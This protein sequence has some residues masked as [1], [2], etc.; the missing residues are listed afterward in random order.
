[1]MFYCIPSATFAVDSTEENEAAEIVPSS[2]E[3]INKEITFEKINDANVSEI[4]S[5]REESVK[6]FRLADGTYQAVAYGKPVHTLSADGT[7]EDIDNGL[8]LT[9]TGTVNT[10]ATKDNRISFAKAFTSNS[11]L[12]TLNE[13]GYT[14]SMALVTN[15]SSDHEIMS[16]SAVDIIQPI[17]T[18]IIPTVSNSPQRVNG[19]NTLD[20]AVLIDNDSSIKYNNVLPNTDIEYVINTG[21]V[22]EN[23]I[24][25]SRASSYSYVFRLELDGLTAEAYNNTV[26]LNDPLTQETI[27][28]I[29]MPYMY[30]ANGELSYNVTYE[31]AEI[32]SGTYALRVVAD[33][34]WINASQR[35]FPVTIDPTLNLI[36]EMDDTYC[37]QNYPNNNYGSGL[38][39]GVSPISMAFIKTAMPALPDGVTPGIS[40]LHLYY[41]SHETDSTTLVGAYKVLEN[42]NE[43]T[44]TWNNKPNID[45]QIQSNWRLYY[46]T[47]NATPTTPQKVW[48][49]ITEAVKDWY[50]NPSSNYGIA[51]K[52]ISGVSEMCFFRT[53]DWGSNL[54]RISISYTFQFEDGVY[55]IE[56]IGNGNYLSFNSST[57]A[58]QQ[59]SYSAQ[60]SISALDNTNRA[61]L[62]KLTHDNNTRYIV[63]LMYDNR[64]TF[65]V[66]DSGAIGMKVIPTADDDVASADTFYI[67][68]DGYGFVLR[69]YSGNYVINAGSGTT[70]STVNKDDAQSSARW[71][72]TKVNYSTTQTGGTVYMQQNIY[73]GH[74]TDYIPMLWSTAAGAETYMYIR[75]GTTDIITGTWNPTTQKFSLTPH[76]P[77]YF[78]V[79]IQI[80]LGDTLLFDGYIENP[81]VTLVVEE[82]NYFIRNKELEKYIQIDNDENVS[83]SIIELFSLNSNDIQ[84]WQIT[85]VGDG[86][87]IIISSLSNMAISVQEDYTNEANKPLIQ[88]IFSDLSCQK[89][90][91]YPTTRSTYILR[92]SSAVD[93]DTDWC[94][95]AGSGLIVEEGR[96]VEQ[97]SYSNDEDYKDEWEFIDFNSAFFGAV[98]I[99]GEWDRDLFFEEAKE[100]LKYVHQNTTTT[101]NTLTYEYISQSNMLNH[102]QSHDI[103]I[104]H[105]HGLQNMFML[106]YDYRFD[107]NGEE[108]WLTMDYLQGKDLSN[109]KLAL[110]ITCETGT[111]YDPAH[112]TS[113]TPVNIIEQMVICGAETVLGF[114]DVTHVTD[115]NVFAKEITYYM[116]QGDTLRRCIDELGRY[117]P[118]IPY[119]FEDMK[120]RVEIA[121]NDQVTIR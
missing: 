99:E 115:G 34:E 73:A 83:G 82:R 111:G 49:Y 42:W 26:F 7:W 21:A 77:G 40:Q 27:Y 60:S 15:S 44:L 3:Y 68:W 6:H 16:A 76:N 93:F 51:I 79:G 69:S 87:Y 39:M 105:T 107:P 101:V 18:E 61:R 117:Q 97:R 53:F 120:D 72:L 45:T 81:S 78:Q 110:L 1:M 2:N 67:D 46:Q 12:F 28:V 58:M 70:L 108:V 88:R 37:E 118:D 98:S 55:A 85:H 24:V 121:G 33:K 32:K 71:E 86:Y 94:M 89:W 5:M 48:F 38:Y 80:K 59:K 64:L 84:K 104:V 113:N 92:P 75:E 4:V 41:F 19:W 36:D 35:A 62:F 23:I 52:Y 91:I 10:Y 56:N 100:Y 31:L 30:D 109:L 8:Y 22:K 65:S 95:S 119:F 106:G 14:V 50:E 25:K 112:I 102:M 66:S 47:D 114:N 11:K 96:D 57:S 116:S 54:P 29:P 63:R 90:K 17:V 74:T 9:Q 103:F 13:N 20:E 43:N